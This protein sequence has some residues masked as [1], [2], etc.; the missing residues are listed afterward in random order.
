[1]SQKKKV[2]V[3]G[4]GMSAMSTIYELLKADNFQGNYDITVYQMGWRIGGKGASGRQHMENP[5]DPNDNNQR[6]LEHGLHAWFC[7]YTNAFNQFKDLY[8]HLGWGDEHRFN[9][10]DKAFTFEDNV[11][12][13]E[14]IIRQDTVGKVEETSVKF[15]LL[16]RG[17]Y[18]M[19]VA[20]GKFRAVETGKKVPLQLLEAENAV[21][22]ARY[23]NADRYAKDVFDNASDLLRQAEAYQA[24]KNVGSRPVISAPMRAVILRM[25]SF[26]PTWVVVMTGPSLL[27]TVGSGRLQCLRD[28]S[29]RHTRLKST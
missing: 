15:D 19:Y 29:A 2:A 8:P 28:Y 5:V 26:V 23:S 3:L 16:K 14:N 4:G 24:R 11:V 27:V 21:Q 22:I 18:T 1:M 25:P 7:W 20:P 17:V 6:I 9:T 13:M 12:V 10:W